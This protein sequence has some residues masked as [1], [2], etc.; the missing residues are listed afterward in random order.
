MRLQVRDEP[1]ET[2]FFERK[3][4]HKKATR[5]AGRAKEVVIEMKEEMPLVVLNTFE[6]LH[7]TMPKGNP[8]AVSEYAQ[9]GPKQQL[10]LMRQFNSRVCAQDA[11]EGSMHYRVLMHAWKLCA[12]RHQRQGRNLLLPL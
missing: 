2:Q 6:G 3:K 1:G 10:K 7:A 11:M 4:Q 12:G 8:V 9:A 5:R